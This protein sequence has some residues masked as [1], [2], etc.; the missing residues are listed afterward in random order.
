MKLEEED[1]L[2]KYPWQFIITMDIEDMNIG[3]IVF[4]RSNPELPMK[5]MEINIE[6]KCIKTN[7]FIYWFPAVC[8]LNYRYRALMIYNNEYEI[9]LN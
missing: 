1:E 8:F 2:Q 7:L 4:L 6:K 3:D 5:I 9:C